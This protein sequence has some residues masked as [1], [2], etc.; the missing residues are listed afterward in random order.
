M[1]VGNENLVNVGNEAVRLFHSLTPSFSSS[2]TQ[3]PFINSRALSPR[4][5]VFNKFLCEN[6]RTYQK[7][8]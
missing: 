5:V 6:L 8:E 1:N 4:N 2:L 7:L 3:A